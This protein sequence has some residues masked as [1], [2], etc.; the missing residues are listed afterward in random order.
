[1]TTWHHENP[2]NYYKWSVIF[3]SDA[4]QIRH[5]KPADKKTI[6]Y[7]DIFIRLYSLSCKSVESTC[8]EFD[9]KSFSKGEGKLF[10]F[11]GSKVNVSC[12]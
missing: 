8:R 4:F 3:K 1:M 10:S 7:T 6:V 2:I 11:F 9:S 5:R 12:G